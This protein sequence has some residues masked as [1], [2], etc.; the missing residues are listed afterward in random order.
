MRVA[1]LNWMQLEA[2]LERDDRI[3]LPLGSTEQHA[4]LSL[5]TDSILAELIAVE[6]AEPLGV[7]VLPALPY[8]VTPW[9]AAYPGSP[10]LR[11]ATYGAVLRDLMSSLLAQ[12]FKRILLL[13]GHGGN[14]P[15][16]TVAEE[17]MSDTGGQAL[18]AEWFGPATE[19]VINDIDAEA[20]HASWW[21]NF[22]ATRPAG[23]ELPTEAK[24]MIDVAA[25]R[26]RP[27]DVVRELIG[28]GSFGGSY[29]RPQEDLERVWRAAVDE[30][31]ALLQSGWR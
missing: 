15:A 12:G 4:Y 3:V 29:V 30:T 9:F 6:A 26:R 24:P 23:V 7:P 18:Y 28:D 19:A 14:A 17:W 21:E 2:Y 27:P 20:A 25:M 5:A 11:L 1:D 13:N 22:A 10:S 16:A 8:G 31:R